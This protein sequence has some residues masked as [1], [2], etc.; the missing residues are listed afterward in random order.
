VNQGDHFRAE[1]AHGLLYPVQVGR[2]LIVV[3]A[4]YFD[5]SAN[6][7]RH[8]A[9]AI[10]EDPGGNSQ[11]LVSG[12]HATFQRPPQSDHALATHQRN[13][14]LGAHYL[15]QS[16]LGICVKGEELRLL[17]GRAIVHVVS[18]QHILAN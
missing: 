16:S 18:G 14:V 6:G 10:P 11:H 12:L 15:P 17:V 8:I 13:L 4:D 2:R 5:L 3:K 1:A 7:T 9:D